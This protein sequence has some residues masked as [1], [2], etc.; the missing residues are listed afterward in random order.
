MRNKVKYVEK[1]AVWRLGAAPDATRHQ[2][3]PNPRHLEEAAEIF[4]E[5]FS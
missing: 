5:G 3:L 1:D 4:E 2:T